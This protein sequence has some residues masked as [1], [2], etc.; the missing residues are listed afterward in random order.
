MT[1][2]SVVTSFTE[3]TRIAISIKADQILLKA[4]DTNIKSEPGFGGILGFM[5]EAPE[6]RF[7][8][9]LA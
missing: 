3:A 6:W 2:L 7:I 9:S 4:I 8:Y 5:R 1:L